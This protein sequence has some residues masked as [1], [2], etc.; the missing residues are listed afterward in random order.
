MSD[1]ALEASVP[2]TSGS[3]QSVPMVLISQVQRNAL[4]DYLSKQPYQDVAAGIAFLRDAP[5]VNV[6]VVTDGG[7]GVGSAES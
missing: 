5:V 4:I 7:D 2:D 3:D 6:N 1:P